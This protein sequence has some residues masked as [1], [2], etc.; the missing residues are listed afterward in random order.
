MASRGRRNNQ[1]NDDLP[2]AKFSIKNFKKSFRLFKYVTDN[3]WLFV[4][5][6]IFLLGTAGVGL[7]F[8]VVAGKM[9]GFFGETQT[10][11]Q[12]LRIEITNAGL[13]LLILLLTQGFFSFGRVYMFSRITEKILK[14][15]RVDLFS[16]LVQMPMSFY[17]KNKVADLSSRVS[18]DINVISEA[19]TVNIAEV[20][21][22]TIVGV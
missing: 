22:Q 6:I 3:K 4:A 13:T 9:F 14:G 11:V 18:N 17:S 21:R 15:L 10:P 20:V 12:Q 1:T 16:K 19:F 7:L 2:K 5:G 8:P